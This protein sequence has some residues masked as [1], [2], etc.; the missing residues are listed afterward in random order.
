M[1][2]TP[3]PFRQRPEETALPEKQGIFKLF[4]GYAPGVGKTYN[5]LAE[6]IRRRSRA[7]DVVIGVVESHGRKPINELS[8]RLEAVPRRKLMYKGRLYEEMDVDAILSRKP[9]VALVDELAHTNVEGSKHTKRYEDVLELLNA[10]IDVLS[11]LNVQ[12]IESVA[13]LVQRI[14]G[15]QIRELVPDRILH[16]VTEI[17]FADLTH[18]ELQERMRRGDI[19]PLDRAD[20]ALGHFFRSGNLIALRE[21]TLQQVTG[22]VGRSRRLQPDRDRGTARQ[23]SGVP[24]RIAVCIKAHPSAQYLIARG[25]RIAQAIEAELFVVYVS[26]GGND[27]PAEQRMLGESLRLAENLG[28]RILRVKGKHIAEELGKV[29]QQEHI[30]EVVFGHSTKSSWRRYLYLSPIHRFLQK[31]LPVDVHIVTYF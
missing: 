2:S 22:A 19:Y 21:L 30:T 9:Q 7:E 27:S 23:I 5:M 12:H 25:F 14:T 26:V 28:A 31:R 6:A 18:E 10:K 3:P 15:V 4:L 29:V 11:T 13:P 17:V 1:L 20:R 16:R 8:S 24:E